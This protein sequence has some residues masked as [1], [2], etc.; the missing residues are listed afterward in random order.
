MP[1]LPSPL[2]SN[3]ST[4]DLCPPTSNARPLTSIGRM[5]TLNART[6]PLLTHAHHVYAPHVKGSLSSCSLPIPRSEPPA[7]EPVPPTLNAHPPTSNACTATSKAHSPTLNVHAPTSNAHAHFETLALCFEPV[8]P[9]SNARPPTLQTR[10]Y[11]ACPRPPAHFEST[12]ILRT[13]SHPPPNAHPPT[14]NARTFTSSARPRTLKA[15]PPTLNTSANCALNAHPRCACAPTSHARAPALQML[16]TLRTP[17]PTCFELRPAHFEGARRLIRINARSFECLPRP[18]NARHPKI[19]T[20]QAHAL[21]NVLPPRC[22]THFE[23]AG[24]C[25]SPSKA[26]PP[27]QPA[28]LAP[29]AHYFAHLSQM[30]FHTH[31]ARH[32]HTCCAS[33]PIAHTHP[34]RTHARRMATVAHPHSWCMQTRRARLLLTHTRPLQRLCIP[35]AA[36]PVAS[37]PACTLVAHSNPS[38]MHTPYSLRMHTPHT[39]ML[40]NTAACTLLARPVHSSRA[41]APRTKTR[42]A[43]QSTHARHTDTHPH[44]PSSQTPLVAP[45]KAL[46]ARSSL[47]HA[48][49]ASMPL[50]RTPRR[51]RKPAAHTR[52]AHTTSPCS[53][54]PM[55]VARTLVVHTHPCLSQACPI[56]HEPG[57]SPPQ[58]QL[59]RASYIYTVPSSRLHLGRSIPIPVLT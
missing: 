38:H 23:R 10:L 31:G 57:A 45:A 34:S 46:H 41:H 12:R 3:T 36:L 26:P 20:A 15:R 14:L 18:S 2:S 33:I 5:L 6:P 17:C 59:T 25:S 28:H 43:K 48:P 29:P 9:S 19:H 21:S 27:F 53:C 40:I 44:P 42:R 22:R 39:Y 51:A 47:A 8:P 24:T 11:F 52:R 50:T 35:H 30:P 16:L 49:T 56:S 37:T 13:P 54:T 58:P 4:S 32:T 1:A 7:F 55:S